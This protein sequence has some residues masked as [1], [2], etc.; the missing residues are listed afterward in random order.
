MAAVTS[1]D[2]TISILFT[3]DDNETE[4]KGRQ[5]TYL[6]YEDKVHIY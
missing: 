6:Y 4:T 1:A 2:R 3:E 5:L